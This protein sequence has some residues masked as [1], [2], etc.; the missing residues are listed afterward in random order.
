MI[1]TRALAVALVLAAG[2]A[3]AA[4]APGKKSAGMCTQ[5]RILPNGRE[6]RSIVADPGRTSVKVGRGIGASAASA[7]SRGS[8]SSSVSVSSSSSSSSSGSGRS[9][10]RAVSSYTDEAGRTVTTTRDGRG[11]TIVSDER[12]LSGEE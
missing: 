1:V 8:S 3:P 6:L 4:S 10:A 11:C 5:V 2:A 9:M 12:D 7:S